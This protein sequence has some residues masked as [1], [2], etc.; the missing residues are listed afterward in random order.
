[1][2]MAEQEALDGIMGTLGAK[3]WRCAECRMSL[4][5]CVCLGGEGSEVGPG[6]RG[7]RGWGARVLGWER[8]LL[9]GEQ[10]YQGEIRW[11]SSWGLRGGRQQVWGIAGRVAGRVGASGSG[12]PEKPGEGWD[13]ASFGGRWARGLIRSGSGVPQEGIRRTAWGLQGR[14]GGFLLGTQRVRRRRVGSGERGVI[15]S[16]P[17]RLP[18]P[19]ALVA[20]AAPA[21][22]SS[23]TCG[24]CS[25]GACAVARADPQPRGRKARE[26]AARSG[27]RCSDGWSR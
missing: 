11:R 21:G 16:P 13:G 5:R 27:R 19:Q 25:A 12:A 10:L 24:P 7:A 8:P 26:D 4:T 18:G 1:M 9:G 23:S 17:S 6:G 14:G 20:R 3:A 2:R 15:S 22:S